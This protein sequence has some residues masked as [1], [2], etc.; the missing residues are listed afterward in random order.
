[1]KDERNNSG[2]ENSGDWNSG[3]WNSGRENSGHGN[4]GRG[5]SGHG[6]SGRGNSGRGNS[7]DW[8]SGNWNSGYGNSTNRES[9]IFCSEESTVRMF[10]KPT[11]LKWNEI[12]HADYSDL[13]LCEWV[14]E[15]R[16]TDE[17][18]KN[19]PDFSVRGGY[20]KTYNYKDAW[21][22]FWDKTDEANKKLILELPNFDAIIFEEIT[23][24]NVSN[25]SNEMT[26]EDLEKLTG[27]KNLKIKK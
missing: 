21:R 6:N 8:N 23:G 24:I 4:S 1:M 19:E 26:I 17:E 10:N 25:E 20:L 5:N 12:I 15:L 14:T 22:N 16:M 13:A 3:D 11:N 18:K 2:R 7:G 9:G 27:I